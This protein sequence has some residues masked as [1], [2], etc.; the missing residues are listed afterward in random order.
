MIRSKT[1]QTTNR[2]GMIVFVI[3]ILASLS[4]DKSLTALKWSHQRV[5][6]GWWRNRKADD[7]NN[8]S[9][10]ILLLFVFT[11][12]VVDIGVD[13]DPDALPFIRFLFL[14]NELWFVI[15]FSQEVE[16]QYIQKW[17][18]FF[19]HSNC[20]TSS[21][22][23]DLHH[24]LSLLIAKYEPKPEKKKTF[25]DGDLPAF[26][27]SKDQI[28]KMF[29]ASMKASPFKF[30]AGIELFETIVNLFDSKK[31]RG[32]VFTKSFKGT[33]VEEGF[34]KAHLF[35]IEVVKEFK[36]S[37]SFSFHELHNRNGSS[38]SKKGINKL[39]Y[40]YDWGFFFQQ[41]NL[42]IVAAKFVPDISCLHSKRWP[43]FCV[44]SFE[45]W[46]KGFQFL[47]KCSF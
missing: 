13:H 23:F 7:S 12:I 43:E 20:R 37:H 2:W 27:H 28:W 1:Q 38:P 35:G 24:Y 22:N 4:Q 15:Y 5:W 3:K 6:T 14:E 31:R 47:F 8:V 16:T 26:L 29:E 11:F 25:S 39:L 17:V 10:N 44:D 42:S 18:Q 9:N 40:F 36:L 46:Q 34:K 19:Q 32:K 45:M 30:Y 33:F 41:L 21:T